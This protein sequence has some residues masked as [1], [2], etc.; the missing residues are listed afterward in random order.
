MVRASLVQEDFAVPD[1]GIAE[2]SLLTKS[3]VWEN[4]F[5]PDRVERRKLH[6]WDKKLQNKNSLFHD[7]SL[8][9]C[10]GIC[11]LHFLLCKIINF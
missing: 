1:I 2:L 9:L 6:L 10:I 7:N 4:G 11:S 3:V 8:E 5:Q